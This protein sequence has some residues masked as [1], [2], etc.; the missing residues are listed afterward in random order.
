[1]LRVYRDRET[2]FV[3]NS[4]EKFSL[5]F[6][7]DSVGDLDLV[8]VATQNIFRVATEDRLRTKHGRDQN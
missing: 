8:E 6:I 2:Y 1:M 4:Y 7:L 3:K 5:K